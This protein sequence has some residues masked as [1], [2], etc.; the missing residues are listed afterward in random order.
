M[1]AVTIAQKLKNLYDRLVVSLGIAN[2][3]VEALPDCY[4]AVEEKGGTLPAQQTATNLPTA[5]ASIP[6]M[7]AAKLISRGGELKNYTLFIDFDGTI[8]FAF[9]PE[10]MAT[11]T[12]LPT[13]YVEH[14]GL[15]FDKWNWTLAELQADTDVAWHDVGAIYYPTDGY[16]QVELDYRGRT[17]LTPHFRMMLNSSDNLLLDWGDG[18]TEE[19]PAA[20]DFDVAHTYASAGKY[21]LKFKGKTTTF[22]G[23]YVYNDTKPYV[24]GRFVFPTGTTGVSGS[25]N[26]GNNPS[27]NTTYQNVQGIGET[28]IETLVL[29]SGCSISGGNSS[30]GL[31]NIPS[32]KSI[33]SD[34][35]PHVW[36][37]GNKQ[38]PRVRYFSLRLGDG[39]NYS[40]LYNI[41]DLFLTNARS[42]FYGKIKYNNALLLNY[43]FIERLYFPLGTY[44]MNAYGANS[45]F[46]T[47]LNL[48]VG[49]SMTWWNSGVARNMG[50]I[51]TAPDFDLGSGVI[52]ADTELWSRQ[53]AAFSNNYKL[54]SYGHPFGNSSYPI[55]AS[56]F[57]NNYSLETLTIK[58]GTKSIAA[59]AFSNCYNLRE[60]HI[61]TS[62]VTDGYICTLANVNAFTGCPSSLKIYVPADSVNDYKAATNWL[63]FASQIEAEPTTE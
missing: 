22:N 40:G 54:K 29:P 28:L 43:P 1:P 8:L 27:E 63:T 60:L 34:T 4:D 61:G 57:A 13:P 53:T 16:G 41:Q 49:N 14:E 42:A 45:G 20:T 31:Y 39:S 58:G 48:S 17:Y 7:E 10:E 33:V 55:L 52:S 56:F 32:L 62:Y 3:F 44:L 38:F 46:L 5:I 51:T 15:T 36:R 37:A 23:L 11:M 26:G 50:Y 18:T 9:T 12:E 30:S 19:L 35:V 59:N 21:L 2:Q 24:I 6:G 25:V 47:S